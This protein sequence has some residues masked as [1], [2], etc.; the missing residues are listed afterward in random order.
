ML[1]NRF[2]VQLSYF[3]TV[4]RYAQTNASLFSND[5]KKPLENGEWKKGQSFLEWRM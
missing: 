5:K 1:T 3:K 2:I 4:T